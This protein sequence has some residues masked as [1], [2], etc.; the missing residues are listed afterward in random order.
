[1]RTATVL[2]A[3]V[4]AG[5][6]VGGAT[7]EAQTSA[8]IQATATVLSALTV[9]AGNNLQFGNVTPGV[10]KTVAITDGGAGTFTVTKAANSDVT[11]SFTLP[12]TLASGANTLPIAGWTGGWSTAADPFTATLFTPSALGTQTGLSG[13]PLTV[14]VGATVSPAAAQAAGT[15]TGN[16]QMSVVY[17]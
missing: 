3:I 4:A 17:F 7:A 2:S 1:M 16:V 13:S 11:L 8:S 9:A 6:T 5:L 10:N 15:Y 12:G 14:Y